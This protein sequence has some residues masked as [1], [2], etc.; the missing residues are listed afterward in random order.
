MAKSHVY[1]HMAS[2]G[3]FERATRVAEGFH[4]DF[5]G[6]FSVATPQGQLYLLTIIDD[7]TRR[8]FPFLVKSQTEWYDIFVKFVV[9]IEAE[10][11]KANCIAWILSDNGAVYTSEQMKTF[12]VSK[13]IQQRFS[14]PY[15]Q[16]MDHTA[17]RNMRT[18]G[19]MGLTTLVHS[20]LPKLAWG[21]AMLHAAEVINR[22]ADSVE[23]NSKAKFPANYSRLEKW[24]NKELPG[25]TKGLYPFGC[26]AFKHV[27]AAV[28]KKLD[29]H[30]VPAVYLGFD[31]KCRAYL[32]GSLYRLDLSTSVE[33]TF[34][35]NVFPFR[36]VKSGEAPASLLYGTDNNL[37]EGDGRFGMFDQPDMS[38]VNKVLD[39][40]AMKSIGVAPVFPEHEQN[41]VEPTPA[42][43]AL[44]SAT[45]PT[46]TLDSAVAPR[47]SSRV[48]LP[49]QKDQFW[50]DFY[51]ETADK[52]QHAMNF[53]MELM[54]LT[55]TQLQSITPRTAD[56]AVHSKSGM[57][58]LAAMN[59][60]K[61]CH[62]KNG[63]F[64]EEWSGPGP[65]PK[66]VPAGWVFKIKHRGDPID[67][68][69]LDTKQFK[70]RVVIRGQ[71]MKE[72]LD[73]NDTFAPVAKPA[74]IRSLLAVAVHKG[75]ILKAGDIETAFLTADMDCEVWVTMPPLWGRGASTITSNCQ[76]HSPP[77]RLL[78]GVP[79]IPQGS[80]LF[81]DTFAAQL[82]LMDFV[83]SVADKCLFLKK[84]RSAFCAVLLWVDDFIFAGDTEAMWDAFIA[85]LSAKFTLTSGDL[86]TFLGMAVTYNRAE[87]TLFLS[88]ASSIKT[89]LERANLAE[90]NAVATPCVVG[91]AWSVKDCP[92]VQASAEECKK[93]RGLVALAN[94]IACWTRP[95]IAFTVNKLCKF[96]SNPGPAHWT[97]LK[98]LLRYLKGSTT[99]GLHFS[100]DSA[101]QRVHGYTDASFADCVDTGKST[102]GYVFLFAGAVL[103]WFSK[104]H[105]YVTTCT[106]HSEYAALAQGAKEAQWLVYL[107]NELLP[108]QAHTPMPIFV[109][110][111]GIVSLVFNP[112]D[113]QSNKHIGLLCHFAREM[114]DLK[115]IAPQRVASNENI[116]DVFTKALGGEVF[117]NVAKLIVLEQPHI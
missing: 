55:E 42:Q 46:P 67:E 7:L 21:Y 88:Q 85:Q 93:Y 104:L 103:S 43:P 73:F 36:K 25:Q 97:A 86:V 63:T 41:E 106:N 117:R 81:Y 66:P 30:A 10:M 109:D 38:G 57:Q 2:P 84:A 82:L 26:L 113:H 112:V 40:Q 20:N 56:Q 110:N 45:L 37:S 6:P 3:G 59:R 24:K 64:G 69:D 100:F 61:A 70:A 115:V 76:R 79:G 4:T 72:G 33:V 62:V 108:E 12:C 114:T 101:L 87:H 102:I 44:P 54:A 8:I 35:E 75:C 58:W 80:R 60:E 83:P 34:V 91:Q 22:T 16:W 48:R 29:E 27:P 31:P 47:R 13:G 51:P 94:F 14:A 74:T 65:C 50:Q 9:R 53:V 99:T 15:A 96:M 68:E 92:Q 77:R 105:T 28:R 107:F 95:D 1:P 98:H 18:I 71:F 23:I 19:E 49:E 89:L 32:L 11:G 78:K 5:R 90:C 116:A 52:Q 17:E 39:Q 111:S